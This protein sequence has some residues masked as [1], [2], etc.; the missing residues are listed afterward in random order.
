MVLSL[1]DRNWMPFLQYFV[2][3]NQC[4]ERLDL[5]GKDRLPIIRDKKTLSITGLE[6][7][8]L[9]AWGLNK[10]EFFLNPHFHAC[11]ERLGGLVVP[12][13]YNSRSHMFA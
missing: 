12:C 6:R 7:S 13:V 2:Y 9:N 8:P 5:V 1:S 11:P 10:V 3:G 4:L